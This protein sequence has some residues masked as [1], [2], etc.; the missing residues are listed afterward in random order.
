M[1]TAR[2]LLRCSIRFNLAREA[3]LLS[4]Y[5]DGSLFGHAASG[6]HTELPLQFGR[7]HDGSDFDFRCHAWAFD[8]Q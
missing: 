6:Q 2:Y 3:V 5:Y 1:T 7:V 8:E 4:S